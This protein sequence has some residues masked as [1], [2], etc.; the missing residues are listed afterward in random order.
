MTPSEFKYAHART[1]IRSKVRAAARL[2]LV[3]GWSMS[4]AARRCQLS[5]QAVHA[6]VRRIERALAVT[7]HTP[8]GRPRKPHPEIPEHWEAV[9]VIVPAE[10]T[11]NVKDVERLALEAWQR[12]RAGTPSE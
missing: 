7:T 5:R 9:T 1:L 10:V 12:Q 3:K 8:R 6:A 11:G 4:D 2:V